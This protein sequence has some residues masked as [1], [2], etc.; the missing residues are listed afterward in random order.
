M[1][2]LISFI[3]FPEMEH[4]WNF[5]NKSEKVMAYR[6]LKK[7]PVFW[8]KMLN[9]RVRWQNICISFTTMMACT[10]H[11]TKEMKSANYLRI[12]IIVGVVVQIVTMK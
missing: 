10:I 3:N 7:G 8:L 11:I 5:H 4:P 12:L 2:L 1:L 6:N 9:H